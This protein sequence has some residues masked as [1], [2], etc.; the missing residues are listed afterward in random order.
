MSHWPL[1][2]PTARSLPPIV[3]TYPQPLIESS[4]HW[5]IEPFT[6]RWHHWIKTIHPF[7]RWLPIDSRLIFNSIFQCDVNHPSLTVAVDHSSLHQTY[8]TVPPI[9]QHLSP[10][11]FGSARSSTCRCD[12]A[13]MAMGIELCGHRGKN[14]GPWGSPWWETKQFEGDAFEPPS[15]CS[16]ISCC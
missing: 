4:N 6:A 8:S 13:G 7:N 9:T 3:N 2:H 14:W 10:V 16:C 12:S 1:N 15:L 5:I 11:N